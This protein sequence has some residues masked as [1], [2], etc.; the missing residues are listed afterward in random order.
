MPDDITQKPINQ[1]KTNATVE[2]V[3]STGKTVD[4]GSSPLAGIFDKI[5][6]GKKDGKTTEEALAP[7]EAVKP[8]EQAPV[9][10]EPK[11]EEV[12][13]VV[14]EVKLDDKQASRQKL[15]EDTE[16]KKA[17][18]KAEVKVE[19]KDD[20]AVKD[21]ELAVLPH[22]KPKTAK[23]IGALLQK[24]TAANAEVATTKAEAVEKAQKLAD[25]EKRLNEVKTVDPK[26]QEE[27][28]RK[29]EE[30]A[31]YRRKYALEN[32]PEVKT[33]FDSKVES[34]EKEVP[35]LLKRNG[36]GDPLLNIIKEEGGWLKFS[37]SAR[38]I[39]LTDGK[40]VT[41]SEFAGIIADSLPFSDR[42]KL[43]AITME[44]IQ[45]QRDKES[46]LKDEGGK[47]TE[48][49]NKQQEATKK[50]TESQQAII[51]ENAKK[52]EAWHKEFLEKTDWL[53][54]KEV[55][56]GATAEQKSAIE[57]DNKYAR[58][59][60]SIFNQSLA[61]KSL[62]ESFAIVED[63]LKYYQERRNGAK[64]LAENAKLKAEIESKD[65][66]L[67]KIKTSSRSTPRGG[68][69]V[70]GGGGG[71]EKPKGPPVGLEAAFAAIERG[72]MGGRGN[73]E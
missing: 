29:E 4:R 47:A 24:I 12:K 66:E 35:D 61:P 36:A 28:T 49:F 6:A 46:F 55:P 23:R 38:Q 69:I 71:E 72:E 48:Y 39:T 19:P 45:T 17:E 25:L 3:D 73:Q 5:E 62:D 14:A 65:K 51:K 37:R 56:T 16:V 67:A 15:F 63:S 58:N 52:V 57:E 27:I 13:P 42:S 59:L 50:Q 18:V 53:K 31:M 40:V 26:V 44:L 7:I 30:L 64:L 20:E 41:G 32:D 22:D 2:V 1:V 70:G 60:K 8:K 43:Q 68:S 11:K 21:D 33:R 9:A 54:E 10:A 34:G